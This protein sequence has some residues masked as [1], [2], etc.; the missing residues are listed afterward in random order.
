MKGVSCIELWADFERWAGR[1]VCTAESGCATLPRAAPISARTALRTLTRTFREAV[2]SLGE[3]AVRA[4]SQSKIRGARLKTL[5][6]TTDVTC[7][8]ALPAW[9]VERQR[10]VSITLLRSRH[11]F[12]SSWAQ[13]LDCG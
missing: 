8:R 4:F 3:E 7:C 12:N 9:T 13:S 11:D 5:G 10:D 1:H 6:Y 2:R